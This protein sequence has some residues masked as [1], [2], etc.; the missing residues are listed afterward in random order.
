[1]RPKQY[2]ASIIERYL[3]EKPYATLDELKSIVGTTVSMTIFRKLKELGYISSCSHRGKYYSLEHI[4]KFDET[5]LWHPDGILFS[6][7]GDL[8]GYSRTFCLLL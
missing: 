4:A 8:V 7:F 3:T 6:K 5:G 2:D 1:M